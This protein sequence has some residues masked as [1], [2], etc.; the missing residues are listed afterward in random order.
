MREF[1]GTKQVK[2]GTGSIAGSGVFVRDLGIYTD[3]CLTIPL[4]GEIH[5]LGASVPG[6]KNHGK[7]K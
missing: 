1:T 3:H 5:R 7:G 6:A 2:Q 4:G